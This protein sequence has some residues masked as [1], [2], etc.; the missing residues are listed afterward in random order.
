MTIDT[1][2]PFPRDALDANRGGELTD[3]QR[4]HLAGVLQRVRQNGRGN[5]GIILVA[6]GISVVGALRAV[7]VAPPSTAA[8]TVIVAILL[9]AAAAFAVGRTLSRSRA[10]AR[11]LAQPTVRSVEGAIG[12]RLGRYQSRSARRARYIDVGDE[13][14]HVSLGM[15]DAAPDAGFVRLYYLPL[16]RHV[17][18]LERLADRAFSAAT[19][20]E[21][22][23]RSVRAA[24]ASHSRAPINEIR[25]EMA[26]LEKLAGSA[27]A[28]SPSPT[29]PPG[30]RDPRPLA[31]SI[32]GTW[33]NALMTV[34][35]SGDGTVTAKL[36]TG[37]ERH[38]HW[39][40]D[41]SGRLRAD[42]TGQ[43]GDANAWITGDQLIIDVTGTAITFTRARGG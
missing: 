15:Y 37:F 2:D 22:L 21:A 5:I 17:V 34:S 9:L 12:K 27:F 7:R 25:A 28:A 23:M 29:P 41:R 36:L 35:F 33:S 11:D 14:F 4:R 3:D 8:L 38:G 42:V 20:P 43:E 1:R 32:L 40:V 26:G 31:D 18:N 10:L 16:S 24:A 39:S 30:S 13:Q 19:S 6:A